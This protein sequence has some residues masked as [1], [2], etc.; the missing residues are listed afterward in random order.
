MYLSKLPYDITIPEMIRVKQKYD[1]SAIDDIWQKIHDEFEK[2]NVISKIK[3]NDKIAIT[4]GSRGINRIGEIL[5]II[6]EEVKS[7]GGCPYILSAM[8]SH[9]GNTIEGQREIL[10][11]YGITEEKMKAPVICEIETVEI[12]KNSFGMPV[13]FDK[14]SM[15][16]DGIIAVNRIKQHTDFNGDIESGVL[17]MLAI[18]LGRGAGAQQIHELGTK[19]MM[20]VMPASVEVILE[21]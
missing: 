6:V 10:E 11:G 2:T 9:G 4:A 13:Y 12:G 17:K 3:E 18:G 5:R 8:G 15:E 21:K 20:E 19:G 14:L 7:A 1:V 16:A